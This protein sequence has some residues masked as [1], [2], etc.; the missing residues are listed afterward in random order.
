MDTHF[1]F[2]QGCPCPLS[3][4]PSSLRISSTRELPPNKGLPTSQPYRRETA[5]QHRWWLW[6]VDTSH[7][8]QASF[9]RGEGVQSSAPPSVLW[10]YCTA[11]N[12]LEI[13]PAWFPSTAKHQAMESNNACV[14]SSTVRSSLK[15]Y[16][17][18]NQPA[19]DGPTP[20]AML[21]SLLIRR[22]D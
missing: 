16:L 2:T 9:T 4:I 15:K 21:V 20:E 14:C 22:R 1:L 12:L 8:L 17:F 19:K 11:D 5:T 7:T 6:R 3:E 18:P 10:K 13:V